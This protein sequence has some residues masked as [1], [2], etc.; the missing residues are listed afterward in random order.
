MPF[1]IPPAEAARDRPACCGRL[2]ASHTIGRRM[3]HRASACARWQSLPDQIGRGE[4]TGSPNTGSPNTRQPEHR[5][6]EG[7]S[8]NRPTAIS[9]K[10]DRHPAAGSA[11]A[12]AAADHVAA[13]GEI[14]AT[15][16]HDLDTFTLNF[17]FF[18]LSP[19]LRPFAG[20]VIRS[21]LDGRRVRGRGAK[22]SS[23]SAGGIRRSH[24]AVSPRL[25]GISGRLERRTRLWPT[26]HWNSIVQQ[27]RQ[28]NAQTRQP[29]AAVDRRCMC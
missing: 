12:D 20:G 19:P 25:G 10:A 28:R 7:I 23:T 17:Q 13:A 3:T 14:S 5:Q 21:F 9:A 16:T 4:T 18:H 2:F 24:G 11:A 15:S 6:P 1:Q 29:R 26:R 27:R 8:N 22:G